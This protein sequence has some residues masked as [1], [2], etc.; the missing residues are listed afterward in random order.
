M[1]PPSMR[2]LGTINAG[3]PSAAEGYED[4]PLNIHEWLVK[5]PTATIFYRV[6]GDEL[7]KEHIC[8]GSMAVVDKSL[9]PPRN[10]LRRIEGK[11][12]LIEHDGAFVI[13]RFCE[14]QQM[15]VCGIVV[16]IVT[17]Y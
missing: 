17:K 3:F 15:E 11:L 1:M 6:Q 16:A 10:K 12:V 13:C 2:F 14:K 9:V 4:P 8:H 7:A 5:N